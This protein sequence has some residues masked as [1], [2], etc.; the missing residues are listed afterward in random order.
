MSLR[1]NVLRWN[2]L[3]QITNPQVFVRCGYPWTKQ[4]VKDT[5][6]SQKMRMEL[7]DL[8]ARA[9][10]RP[11][12]AALTDKDCLEL[13][14]RAP[15]HKELEPM[16]D[17]LAYLILKYNRFGG[18]ERKF[19]TEDKPELMG[20]LGKVWQRKVVKSGR[21][22]PASGGY[23]YYYGGYDYDPP[24]LRDEETHVIHLISVDWCDNLLHD[25]KDSEFW[26]PKENLKKLTPQEY[27]AEHDQQLSTLQTPQGISNGIYAS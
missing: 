5:I 11:S 4:Y 27:Y 9:T 23:D 17:E 22:Q 21:Y 26:I 15:D 12:P 6:I 18:R 13:F 7:A 25:R 10:G 19:Y 8:V 16:I 24:M 3:V 1:K 20:K 2:D 14:M